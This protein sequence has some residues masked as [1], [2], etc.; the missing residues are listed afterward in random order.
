MVRSYHP[1]PYAIRLSES[2]DIRF[3]NV[4]VDHNSAMTQC[5]ESGCRQVTRSGK[6][7]FDTCILDATLGAEVRD[8]EFAWL[9]VAG[10]SVPAKARGTS[11]VE[12][13]SGGFYNISGGAV[14][15]A[16]RPCP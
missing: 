15:A 8:R 4:H 12:K 9:D 14:D 6:V 10:T 16:G 3:R 2:S 13:L 5:N 7:S 1:V 11:T